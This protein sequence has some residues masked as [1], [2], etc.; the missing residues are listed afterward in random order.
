M[1]SIRRALNIK[2]IF[3]ILLEYINVPESHKDPITFEILFDPVVANDGITYN[4]DTADQ[5]IRNNSN[6]STGVRLKSYVANQFAKTFMMNYF[7]SIGIDIAKI[8]DNYHNNRITTMSIL[9]NP[10]GTSNI[11]IDGIQPASSITDHS[12][13][14]TFDISQKMCHAYI[15]D[16]SGSM[17]YDSGVKEMSLT[18]LD[19]VKYA[20]YLSIKAINT[21]DEIIV[22]TFNNSGNVVVDLSVVTDLNRQSIIDKILKISADG[23]TDIVSGIDKAA[24]VAMLRSYGNVFYHV[25]TDGE[26]TSGHSIGRSF[27]QT[28]QKYNDVNANIAIYGFS[29]A[30]DVNCIKKMKNDIPFYFI[31]D[32]SMLITAF[33]NGFANA[34]SRSTIMI[35]EFFN[36]I[37]HIIIK[38]LNIIVIQPKENLR[39]EN[40]DNLILKFKTIKQ[41]INT[42]NLQNETIIQFIDGLLL[43]FEESMDSSLGQVYKA[44]SEKYFK[45]WGFPYLNS[46]L[47][48]LLNKI[49]VNY[50]DNALKVFITP[51]RQELIEKCEKIVDEN[52]FAKFLLELGQNRRNFFSPPIFHFMMN[53][54]TSI[55]LSIYDDQGGCFSSDSLI[56][57]VGK[58]STEREYFSST[59]PISNVNENMLV[60]TNK[61][62][63]KVLAKTKLFYHGKMYQVSNNILLTPY[64]PILI[65]GVSEFPINMNLN[66]IFYSGYVYDLLL[67]DRGLIYI[68]SNLSAASLNHDCKIGIFNHKYF[69]TKKI[70][71]DLSSLGVFEVEINKHDLLRDSNNEVYTFDIDNLHR[72]NITYKSI[73]TI[74]SQI[75]SEL[76]FIANM[77]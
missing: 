8:Y 57:V 64:H 70:E 72:R 38:E 23:G 34:N 65:N 31:S 5:M 75:N 47:S 42:I 69:G 50:K 21:G 3:A 20:M 39:K 30:A 2:D 59:I 44:I 18:R 60:K 40:L 41:S 68:D 25:F 17:N 10:D 11:L 13:Q 16:V 55:P 66:E 19:V 67:E 45:E 76:A 58:F 56:T 4:K 61:G 48:S 77:V 36:M 54:N 49:C 71:N 15:L 46:Y 7:E 6:S 32:T 53:S 43:D 24:E 35:D 27:Q 1:S 26:D 33:F 37:L 74:D 29:P 9:N 51:E 63:S 28:T 22:V 62:W 73:P 52:N 12:S 14:V